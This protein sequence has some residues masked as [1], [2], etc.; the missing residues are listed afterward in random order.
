MATKKASARI[1]LGV[2]DKGLI[3]GLKKAANF[4]RKW[5]TTINQSLEIASKAFGLVSGAVGAIT[6]AVSEYIDLANEQIRV[7]RRLAE[8][9][10]TSG[11]FTEEAF[12]AAKRH[13]S[14]LQAQTTLGDEYIL[15]IKQQLVTQGVATAQLDAATEAVLGAVQARVREKT[16]VQEVAKTYRGELSSTLKQMGLTGRD[17]AETIEILR[18]NMALARA[19]ADTYAGRMTQLGNAV[20]DFKEELGFAITRSTKVQ[21]IIKALTDAVADL[22]GRVGNQGLAQ[23]VDELVTSLANKAFPAFKGLIV[24]LDGVYKYVRDIRVE[25]DEWMASLTFFKTDVKDL[26]P[27]LTR[28]DAA[29]TSVDKTAKAMRENLSPAARELLGLVERVER[30]LNNTYVQVSPLLNDSPFAQPLGTGA[31]LLRGASAGR[32]GRPKGKAKGGAGEDPTADLPTPDQ[33]IAGLAAAYDS[34]QIE[35]RSKELIEAQKRINEAQRAH[36]REAA[37]LERQVIRDETERKWQLQ[38]ELHKRGIAFQQGLNEEGL[39]QLI[40]Q[41]NQ[42]IAIVQTVTETVG[43][44]VLN[45]SQAILQGL[46]SASE[47]STKAVVAG[48]AKNL[49]LQFALQANAYGIQATVAGILSYWYPPKAEEAA[50]FGIAAGIMAGAAATFAGVSASLGGFS[51]GAGAAPRSGAGAGGAGGFGGGSRVGTTPGTGGGFEDPRDRGAQTIVYELHLAEKGL[52]AGDGRK[53]GRDILGFIRQA[54]GQRPG[55]RRAA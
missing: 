54:E 33:Y 3:Q 10:K 8:A 13:A 49:A 23:S 16:A 43:N 55:R 9:L 41:A 17:A 19:D 52:V 6:S 24:S 29:P 28:L 37:E 25:W 38:L 40:D 50:A 34:A 15:G 46:A 21:Q 27:A 26:T 47:Q 5:A 2:N 48:I 42:R 36:I 4:T 11:E 35:E 1:N 22:T 32:R 39:Q 51:K 12:A 45:A 30:S 20:G 53:I 7:E 18:S 31:R 14:A 44:V